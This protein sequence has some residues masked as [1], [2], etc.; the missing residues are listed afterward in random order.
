MS[1][2]ETDFWTP[3]DFFD[4]VE[5]RFGPFD[6]D[7]AASFENRKCERFY[8]KRID[9][10]QDGLAWEGRVWCNPPYNNIVPW[11]AK[12]IEQVRERNAERVVM[13]LPAGTSSKW[14]QLAYE[15]AARIE[16]VHG[17]LNFGGPHA[18][19]DGK[20]AA[21]NPSILVVFDIHYWD[22]EQ[23][24]QFAMINRKG[25]IEWGRQSLLGEWL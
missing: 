15:N 6:V 5:A 21:P 12:A 25:V 4:G 19:N 3:N 18:L 14:F 16:F 17:R 1:G 11:V 7:V 9:A 2:G 13:L 8:D 23:G 24:P 10:L 22:P 20:S